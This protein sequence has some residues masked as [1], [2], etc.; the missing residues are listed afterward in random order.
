MVQSLKPIS[1][2]SLSLIVPVLLHFVCFE[3]LHGNRCCSDSNV[4]LCS[5]GY[6]GI[7]G[8]E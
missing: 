6:V 8:H 1:I 3:K 5:F 4:S 7:S 2:V